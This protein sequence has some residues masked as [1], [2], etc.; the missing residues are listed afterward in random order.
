MKIAIGMVVRDFRSA[1]P[2]TEFLDNAEKHDHAIDRVIIA[3]SH[4]MDIAAERELQARTK[5]SLIRLQEFGRAYLIL[6]EIGVSH[7][8]IQNLLFCP[9]IDTHGLVPYGF[10]RNQVLLEALFTET[11]ILL[12]VDSDVLPFTLRRMPDGS[13]QRCEVDFVGA[14]LRSMA[15]GADITSSDYSGYN[16]LPPAQFD[17]MTDLLWGLHKENMADFWQSSVET[18]GMLLQEGNAGGPTPTT[19][20]LGGNL[21]LRMRAFPAFPPFFSPYYFF[22]KTPLLARGEDTLLGL[23]AD[24]YHIKCVDIQTPIFHDTY[25]NYPK[26]PDLRNDSDV[27]DRLYYACTGWIGRNVFYRWKT[28]HALSE[29]AQRNQQLSAGAKALYRYTKDRRFLRLPE[30]QSAAEAWLPDM[31]W[32]Y[33]RS[34]EAWTEFTERWFGR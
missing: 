5:V 7:T 14:H 20:I 16:I 6:K 12:F 29:F 34:K 25:G 19:K 10:N 24:Q 3:Y 30:V 15:M 18:G 23:A 11:D 4:Q 26:V 27:C 13:A 17:G 22:D 28:G 2:L 9:L 21:G 32:Q 8:S 33:Q 1:K 31:I